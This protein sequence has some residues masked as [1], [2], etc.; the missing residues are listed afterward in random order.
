[1]RKLCAMLLTGLLL[2]T[3]ACG[4]GSTERYDSLTV[5]APVQTELLPELANQVLRED[6]ELQRR[7]NGNWYGWW[8]IHGATGG[9]S[10]LEK[11]RCDLCARV[12]ITTDA[13]GT[14]TLWDEEHSADQ[15][16]G[17]VT[18]SL[19]AGKNGSDDGIATAKSGY[20]AGDVLEY[21]DWVI[22]PAFFTYEDMLLIE[23]SCTDDAG[24]Y[25]Y[26]VFLRPWGRRWDDVESAEAEQ[27]PRHY[28][29]WYLPALESNAAMPDTV[30]GAWTADSQGATND[31]TGKTAAVTLADGHLRLAYSTSRYGMEVNRLVS[32]S[33][34]VRLEAY[35]CGDEEAT[36]LRSR[37][38]NSRRGA[39]GYAE[40]SLELDGYPARMVQWYDETQDCTVLEYLIDAGS[41]RPG[42]AAYLYITLEDTDELAGIQTVIDALH[43]H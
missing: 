24:S 18:L 33:G 3:A 13:A 7:W 37:E 35:W 15:P 8:E 20:F 9:Y 2:L 1:M 41:I 4:A 21:G 14:V 29:D 22:E 10:E 31:P 11:Q 30:N 16:L 19:E 23:G 17:K 42:A 25:N 34:S 39:A 5:D 26:S 27:L 40:G 36:S 43:L 38:L 32:L 28:Y 12:E 6:T